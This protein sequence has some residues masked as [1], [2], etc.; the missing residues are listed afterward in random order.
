[1]K[2]KLKREPFSQESEL[3][4]KLLFDQIKINN[5]S[6]AGG[7]WP[8]FTG[9]MPVFLPDGIRIIVYPDSHAPACHWGA[10]RGIFD[11]ARWFRPHINVHLG[12]MIDFLH[13]S[14]HAKSATQPSPSSAQE[15]VSSGFELL[16]M[17]MINGSA[18]VKEGRAFWNVLFEGNHEGRKGRN[19]S[20]FSPVW[21]QY[22]NPVTRD[23]I[24]SLQS[25]LGLTNDQPITIVT[26]TGDTGGSDGCLLLNE[27]LGIKHGRYVRRIP[28]DSARYHS[29]REGRS[30]VGGHTHRLGGSSYETASGE[31]ISSYEGGCII[32][33]RR[34]E[35]H[36]ATQEHNWH[37]G[38]LVL[39]VLNGRVHV[40]PIPIFWSA[41]QSGQ[42][43]GWFSYCDQFG[44][45]VTFRCFDI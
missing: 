3:E 37:H 7:S 43:F 12:D 26:G 9:L 8:V 4:R 16:R 41:D 29:E 35:F 2:T 13:L 19:L 36:Y 27:H 28:G 17:S 33:W 25:L 1:M 44:K 39:H 14:M 21:A 23:P 11:F 5:L 31:S 18:N 10:V 45:P 42:T 15:E 40:Q 30:Y 24:L 22:Q 38:F 34:P 32:D 6:I 20:Y